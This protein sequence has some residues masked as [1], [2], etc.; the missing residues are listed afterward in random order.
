MEGTIGS[1]S[2]QTDAPMKAPMTMPGPEDAARSARSDGQPGGHD[3]GERQDEDDPQGQGQELVT[4]ALLDPAVSGAEDLGDDQ[5]DAAD[6]DPADG[7][8]H[9]AGQREPAEQRRDAVEALGVEEPDE[10]A[11]DADQ[12][13]PEE[14]GRDR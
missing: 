5:S 6:D 13:E 9:P 7:R 3:A 12:G 10:A 4:E 11:Q 14:L 2:R 1:N 8:L